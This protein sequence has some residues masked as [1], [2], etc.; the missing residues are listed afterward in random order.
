V[1]VVTSLAHSMSVTSRHSSGKKLY[2]C[3]DVV[4]DTGTP[5]GDAALTFE[6]LP[7]KAGALSTLLGAALLNAVMA[8]AIQTLLDQG[9]TPPVFI[10]ANVDGSDE[11]NA[12][13]MERYKEMAWAPRFFF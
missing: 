8:E 1:I 4:L 3:G 13:L 7:T 12:A 2:E 10:S 6:G 5:I 9:I 11:H